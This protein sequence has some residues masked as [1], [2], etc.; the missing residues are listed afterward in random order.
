MTTPD[1]RSENPFQLIVEDAPGDATAVVRVT[2]REALSQLWSFDV[3]LRVEAPGLEEAVAALVGRR[4][5]LVI[6][7]GDGE[8]RRPQGVI[9]RVR[10]EARGHERGVHWLRVTLRPRAWTLTRRRASRV[11][12][13]TT[14]AAIAAR[15]LESAGIPHASRLTRDPRK[16]VYCTQY[17]ESDWS[18]LRRLLAEDGL[19]FFFEDPPLGSPLDTDSTL[20]LCDGPTGYARQ[21]SKGAVRFGDETGALHGREIRSFGIVRAA[22]ANAVDLRHFDYLRPRRAVRH[23][24]ATQGDRLGPIEVYEHG[25]EIAED[26]LPSDTAEVRLEQERSRERAYTAEGRCRAMAVGH[27]FELAEHPDHA[28][29]R[30]YVVTAIEH[31][32]EVAIAG[33]DSVAGP[34]YR[35][36]FRCLGAD[37]MVRPKAP[38]RRLRQVVET[39]TVVGPGDEEIHVDE[40]GRVKVQFHWD[41]EGRRDETSSCWVRVMQPWAGAGWGS[42][43]IPRV[44]M[45]VVVSFVGGDTDRPVVLGAVYNGAHPL[46]FPLPESKTQSGI[47]TASTPG[48][49]GANQL[50]FEDARGSEQ[51]YI[52]AQRDLEVVVEHDHGRTVHGK[53]TARIARDLLVEVRGSHCVR[54]DGATGDVDDLAASLPVRRAAMELIEAPLAADGAHEAVMAS[55]EVLDAW[56]AFDAAHAPA[57]QLAGAEELELATADALGSVAA[58]RREVREYRTFSALL[59]R[60]AAA[61][62]GPYADRRPL[63]DHEARARSL[64]AKLAARGEDLARRS[65]AIATEALPSELVATAQSAFGRAAHEV[66]MLRHHVAVAREEAR[67]AVLQPRPEPLLSARPAVGYG[68]PAV[69]AAGPPDQVTFLEPPDGQGLRDESEVRASWAMDVAKTAAI[70]AP[71]GFKLEA[72]GCCIELRGGVLTLTGTTV[73]VNGESVQ[74]DGKDVV[75]TGGTIKLN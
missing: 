4:A 6:Q 53:E 33:K 31:D 44:G 58:L 50:R 9:Q 67:D 3:T 49:E 1:T 13:D 15:V 40:H 25:Y 63:F 43:F 14:A 41:R 72:G 12:Q 37:T 57:E 71:G 66:E 59:A 26:Q 47:R 29:D 18:F 16:R 21:A 56:V 62:K 36:R 23:H 28:L 7:D 70:R 35:N 46:P 69:A 34:S 54:I 45:E 39:A 10:S 68:A 17:Q 24:A 60:R 5:R 8:A 64:D 51:I 20:V 52:H 61:R 11:F 65:A 30:A 42:Q 74:V 27:V 32:G 19:C 75:M 38:R 22:T 2:G 48:G 73:D 55:A